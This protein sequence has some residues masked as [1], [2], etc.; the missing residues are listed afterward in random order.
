M[1]RLLLIACLLLTGCTGLPK[2]VEPIEN[3]ELQRYLGTWYEIARLDHRFERG[4][5]RVT[6]TY[7]ARA[8]G[9]VT[10]TNRGYSAKGDFEEAS[11]R[12][13]FVGESSTGHLKV[14][15]FGPFYGSYVIFNLDQDYQQAFISGHNKKY[16]WLLSRTPVVE[17]ATI[18]RFKTEAQRLGFDVSGLIMVDQSAI[19]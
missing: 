4:L 1:Y 6:A 12:A 18:E 8:D 7:S 16:L 3:F 19:E 17:P 5:S 11:G 15:F 10:V 13:Y 14:S 9:G 2:G